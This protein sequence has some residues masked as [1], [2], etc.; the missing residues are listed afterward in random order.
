MSVGGRVADGQTGRT[1]MCQLFDSDESRADAVAAFLEEGLLAREHVVAVL[2]PGTWAGVR[3]RLEEW[4]LPVDRLLADGHLVVE[5]AVDMLRRLTAGTA[6]NPA[7][8]EQIVGTAVRGL[9]ARGR[10]RAY[11]EMVDIL[12]QRG[13]L[14]DALTLEWM[15]N[16]LGDTVPFSLLCGYSTGHFVDASAHRSLRAVCGAHTEVR[17]GSQ[18]ALADWLLTGVLDSIDGASSRPH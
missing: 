9:A 14:E 17:R 4:D 2:R 6:P 1:H 10:M 7:A 15:W 8:F 12:A 16:R 5:D 13:D 18:D 11:G 3:R